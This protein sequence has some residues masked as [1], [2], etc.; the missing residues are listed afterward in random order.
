ML[1][2]AN[3]ATAIKSFGH[4]SSSDL[5]YL[6]FLLIVALPC[7]DEHGLSFVIY[8]TQSDDGKYG[9]VEAGKG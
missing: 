7:L 4:L 5:F 1:L 9:A 2:H 3:E 8:Q 6:L